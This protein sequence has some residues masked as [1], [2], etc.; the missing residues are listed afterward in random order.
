M[1]QWKVVTL[2]GGNGHAEILKMLREVKNIVITAL[3]TAFDDGGSTGELL[4]ANDRAMGYL[5]D[6]TTCATALGSIKDVTRFF[7]EDR[8]EKGA[9]LAGHTLKNLT[10]LRMEKFF[11]FDR[12]RAFKAFCQLC[13]TG[14]HGVDAVADQRAVLCAKHANGQTT[15]GE[16]KIGNLQKEGQRYTDPRLVGIDEDWAI[17]GLYLGDWAKQHWRFPPDITNTIRARPSAVKVLRE[18]DL[19]VIPMGNPYTSLCAS[20][21]AP[22]IK[23]AIAHANPVTFLFLNLTTTLSEDRDQGARGI[24]E[25]IEN[26]IGRKCD[27]IIYNTKLFPFEML[28]PSLAPRGQLV[29]REKDTDPGDTRWFGGPL[30][31]LRRNGVPV[32]DRKETLKLFREIFQE[33]MLKKSVK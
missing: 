25:T 29:V 23:E 24:V 30:A 21:L 28:N 9:G 7:S 4:K 13:G 26:G 15:V 33:E 22:G 8:F 27:F 32:H 18:A 2:G 12:G 16:Y 11:K 20:T 17:T 19:L 10:L 31:K 1:K 6:F 14:A 3:V 5:A